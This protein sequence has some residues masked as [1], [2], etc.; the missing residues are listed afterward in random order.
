MVIKKVYYCP[1]HPEQGVGHY[2][3]DSYFRKPNPGMIVQAAEEFDIN[4]SRSVLVGDKETDILA[5]I[6][7]GVGCNLLYGKAPLDASINT[8]ATAVVT[9]LFQIQPFLE[10]NFL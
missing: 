5:G 9:S 4:L 2:K 1:F 8:A 3:V 7:A 10:N 6:A